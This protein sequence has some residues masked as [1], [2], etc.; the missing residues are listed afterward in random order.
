[1]DQTRVKEQ[2]LIKFWVGLGLNHLQL[3]S[4]LFFYRK[5]PTNPTFLYSLKTTQYIHVSLNKN[6]FMQLPEYQPHAR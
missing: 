3:T 2:L 4:L 6:F 1:M 5:P